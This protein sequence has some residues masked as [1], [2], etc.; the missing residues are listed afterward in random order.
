MEDVTILLLDSHKLTR[1]AFVSML[2][3]VPGFT[4]TGETGDMDKA[5]EYAKHFSPS[6]IIIDIEL[7]VN[8]GF[9]ATKMIRKVSPASK[10][11][12]VS[13]H[14]FP[15][16]ARQMLHMG[17]SGFV[18]KNSPKEELIQAIEDVLSGKNYIC[19]EIKDIITHNTLEE[20]EETFSLIN[21]IS[22][23]ELNI[24]HHIKEGSSSREIAGR[25]GIS[26]KTVQA[27]RYNILKKLKLKNAASLVN[28]MNQQ[29]IE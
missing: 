15:A 19:N 26:E 1:D 2:N 23:R 7:G 17:A 8:N 22:V 18:T 6:I 28:Y 4:V 3:S 10:I 11:I 13:M 12:G 21:L 20:T 5:I 27:H 9:D 29:Q 24:M 25:L 14:S 16:Y